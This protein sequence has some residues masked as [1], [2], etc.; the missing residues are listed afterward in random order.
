MIF[1]GKYRGGLPVFFTKKEAE[2]WRNDL[3]PLQATRVK[4]VLFLADASFLAGSPTSYDRPPPLHRHS[5]DQA[6]V[7][8]C[9]PLGGAPALGAR[10]NSSSSHFPMATS[11]VQGT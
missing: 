6:R 11:A 3:T 1:A 7:C 9:V 5:A 10:S 8:R 2:Q 4:S